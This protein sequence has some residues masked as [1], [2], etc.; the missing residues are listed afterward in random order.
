MN[1]EK[2]FDLLSGTK[3]QISVLTLKRLLIEIKEY[4][5]DICVRYRLLGEMWNPSFMKVI[6]VSGRGILL[7]DES[8]N[9]LISLSDLGMV[10]QFEIDNRFRDIQPHFHYEVIPSPEFNR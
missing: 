6:L 9:R 1:M 3:S 8:A 2:N 5:P 7:S 4:R 10:M